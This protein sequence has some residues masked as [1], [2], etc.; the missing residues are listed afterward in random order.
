MTWDLVTHESE[1]QNIL[2]VDDHSCTAP[3]EEGEEDRHSGFY[4]NTRGRRLTLRR[5]LQHSTL[6]PYS[7]NTN[8]CRAPPLAFYLLVPSTWCQTLYIAPMGWWLQEGVLVG[9]REL[10]CRARRCGRISRCDQPCDFHRLRSCVRDLVLEAVR[11]R[12]WVGFLSEGGVAGPLGAVSP[13]PSCHP[14]RNVL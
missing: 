2:G 9:E 6:S 8:L 12:L 10:Q 5:L 11:R 1:L 3:V 14:L 7:L 13:G 4:S